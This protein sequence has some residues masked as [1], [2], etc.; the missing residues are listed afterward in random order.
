MP[1]RMADIRQKIEDH[2]GSSVVVT[3]NIGR[4][5]KKIRQGILSDSY[6]SI[7]VV[8]L[9]N[10]KEQFDCVSYSYTDI[11]TQDIDI[12]FLDD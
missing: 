10:A 5:K 3:A 8:T 4:K 11:L 7:F 1:N 2:L 12:E 9:H 6:K